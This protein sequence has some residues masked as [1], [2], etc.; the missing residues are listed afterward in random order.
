MTEPE[1]VRGK[2]P[3][4]KFSSLIDLG[5][6]SY[7]I[8]KSVSMMSTP[9]PHRK[10]E[11]DLEQD[12]RLTPHKNPLYTPAVSRDRVSTADGDSMPSSGD[13]DDNCVRNSRISHQKK[14]ND[15]WVMHTLNH[16]QNFHPISPIVIH[17]L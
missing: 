3:S 15:S 4:V 11:I 17:T 5:T 12:E 14:D 7:H 9:S 8:L 2:L 16:A 6:Q 10:A 13:I 1:F